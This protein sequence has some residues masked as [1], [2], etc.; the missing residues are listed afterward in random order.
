M[1]A[2]VSVPIT[3]SVEPSDAE[4]ASISAALEEY[5]VTALSASVDG[6]EFNIS[7]EA[8]QE[9]QWVN[10]QR[11]EWLWVASAKTAGTQTLRVSVT[12]RGKPS[13]SEEVVEGQ[14]WSGVVQVTVE[15]QEEGGFNLGS[16][17]LLTLLN[18]LAGLGLTFP[19]IHE[20]YKRRKQRKP[21]AQEVS[22]E[23]ASGEE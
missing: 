20:Q 21:H 18:T 17:D 8:P 5:G 22:Q 4:A 9:T 1:S 23:P 6:P 7:P 16:F 10:E 12:A 15:E 19:W 2:N 14:I 11:L 13:W 3:V